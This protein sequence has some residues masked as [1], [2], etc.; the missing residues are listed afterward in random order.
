MKPFPVVCQGKWGR[1]GYL[2]KNTKKGVKREKDRDIKNK[3]GKE[4][5]KF[6]E[7]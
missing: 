7:H 6:R 4:R 1:R 5:G 3:K 2:K